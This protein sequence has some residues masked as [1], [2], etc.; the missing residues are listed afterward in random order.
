MPKG[1]K[2]WMGVLFLLFCFIQ[3][4]LAYETENVFI[5]VMD[6]VRNMEAFA[7]P[8]HQYIPNI[9]NNLRP[10]G[11]IFT[12]AYYDH[13]NTYTTPSHQTI[14]SGQ[15][16]SVPNL[17]RGGLSDVRADAPTIFEYYRYHV[18]APQSACAVV[19]GK[20]CLAQ[21]DWSLEPSFGPPYNSNMFPGND[22]DKTY[23]Q[24][25][26]VLTRDRPRLVLV[27]L[28][29]VDKLGHTGYWPAYVDAIQIADEVVYQIWTELIQGDPVYRDRTTMIFLS[30]HGRHLPGFGDFE[31]HAGICQGDRHVPLLVIGPDTPA[32]KVVNDRRY[33]TDLAST[34]GEL[35]GFP[36]PFSRGQTLTEIFNEALK[37]D[38]RQRVYQE[39]PKVII[40][41]QTVYVFWSENHSSSNDT[42]IKRVYVKKKHFTES[43]FSSPILVN[44]PL[45]TRLAFSPSLSVDQNGLHVVWS[46][47]RALDEKG[48][49]WS[50]FYRRSP[51]FGTNWDQ[52]K[53]IITSRFETDEYNKARIIGE[54]LILSNGQSEFIITGA[55]DGRIY[56]DITSFRSSDGGITWTE[57]KVHESPSGMPARYMGARM[58]SPLELGLTWMELAQTPGQSKGPRNYEIFF[59][60]TEDGGETWIDLVRLTED[61]SYSYTPGVAWGNG[62][63]VVVWASR[64]VSG[65]PWQLQCRVSND[66]GKTWGSTQTL[67]PFAPS[68]SAWQPT[69]VWDGTKSK[70]NLI[71]TESNLG[72]TD[73]YRSTS[74]DGITWS[75]PFPAA[76]PLPAGAIR[77]KPY[78]T[79]G[80]GKMWL[81]WEELDPTTRDWMVQ[82]TELN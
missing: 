27:N 29:D 7:D 76:A 10:Q 37:V 33:L 69:L 56:H 4:V 78:V 51:D 47:G 73:L 52:E 25:D 67:T 77:Q 35:L 43:S 80:D 11:T 24:L 13:F 21:L 59:K 48:D 31:D 32:G 75:T 20:K 62:K 6:G 36:T 60:R 19:T 16:Y 58:S 2:N 41:N 3:P 12:E 17:S 68:G 44:D 39:N 34:V 40:Y 65:T 66:K 26:R 45:A 72:T 64:D 49:T 53:L 50:N 28:R 81:V 14:L 23:D 57:K 79:Y 15:W 46:D 18:G 54:P 61:A 9:W 71:W 5:V 8:T 38:M 70:F 74:P 82:S 42:G 55:Y 63:L 30:D 1:R 22:D